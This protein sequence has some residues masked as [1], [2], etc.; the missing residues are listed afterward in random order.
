VD[1]S[2]PIITRYLIGFR[3]AL[4]RNF[5]TYILRQIAF[6][7]FHLR[8]SPQG[9]FALRNVEAPVRTLNN[10]ESIQELKVYNIRRRDA[11]KMYHD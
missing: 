9:D 4:Y 6:M 11:C 3:N 8:I 7:G 2:V 5:I 1:I 10:H